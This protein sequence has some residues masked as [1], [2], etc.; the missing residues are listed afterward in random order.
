M[1]F[2]IVQYICLL[3]VLK[4]NERDDDDDEDD[5]NIYLFYCSRLKKLV[6]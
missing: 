5:S 2:T 3:K 4:L 1:I 6:K